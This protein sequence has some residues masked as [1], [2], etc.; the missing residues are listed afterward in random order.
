MKMAL[1][2]MCIIIGLINL[3]FLE[4]IPKLNYGLIWVALTLQLIR[5]L[6][7]KGGD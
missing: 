1:L 2:I 5:N 4:D 3:M 6:V 7:D